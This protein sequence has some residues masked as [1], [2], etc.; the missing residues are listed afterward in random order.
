VQEPDATEPIGLLALVPYAGFVVAVYLGFKGRELA[1]R[2]KRWSSAGR[3]GR[4]P[5]G[6]VVS[7][8]PRRP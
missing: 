7:R 5:A 6:R 3:L 8:R 1:W 4:R 2:A